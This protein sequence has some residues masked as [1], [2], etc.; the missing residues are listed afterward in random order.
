MFPCANDQTCNNLP[1]QFPG[2]HALSSPDLSHEYAY[3]RH[4][5]QH[6]HKLIWRRPMDIAWLWGPSMCG[7]MGCYEWKTT[8]HAPSII[9]V[10]TEMELWDHNCRPSQRRSVFNLKRHSHDYSLPQAS[11]HLLSPAAWQRSAGC[12]T[13]RKWSLSSPHCNN[14]TCNERIHIKAETETWRNTSSVT[15]LCGEQ[16]CQASVNPY[17]TW[18]ACHWCGPGPCPKELPTQT[19]TVVPAS[20]RYFPTHTMTDTQLVSRSYMYC[21]CVCTLRD[22]VE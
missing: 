4:V 2:R 22:E 21:A 20:P 16:H 1:L 15:F 5:H 9:Y 6:Q 8:G 10:N 13:L 12:G 7:W 3:L 18:H 11:C 17:R 14:R 19:M